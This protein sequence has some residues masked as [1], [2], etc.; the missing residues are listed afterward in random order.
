VNMLGSIGRV[1][2]ELCLKLHWGQVTQGEVDALVHVHILQELLYLLIS[3]SIVLIIRQVYL[4]FFDGVHQAFRIAVLPCCAHFSHTDVD[5]VCAQQVH[6]VRHDSSFSNLSNF[7][8]ALQILIHSSCTQ[9][10]SSAS[11]ALAAALLLFKGF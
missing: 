6:I 5:R 7:G 2:I 1:R 11:C 8:G 10:K 4:L 9:V 3:L